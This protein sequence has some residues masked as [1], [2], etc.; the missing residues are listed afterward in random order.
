LL[1]SP[2]AESHCQ[3]VPGLQ[4]LAGQ[5]AVDLLLSLGDVDPKRIAITGASGGG[6]QS[7]IGAAIDPRIS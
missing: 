3:S 5:R 6:T 7:F 2:M 1:F 4:T